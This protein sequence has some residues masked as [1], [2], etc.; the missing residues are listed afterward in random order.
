M[1]R[2]IKSSQLHLPVLDEQ[3]AKYTYWSPSHA[4]EKQPQTP[5]TGSNP[6]EEKQ[7]IAL[8]TDSR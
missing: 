3:T 2:I 4:I 8:K 7:E 5:S 1:I 6:W